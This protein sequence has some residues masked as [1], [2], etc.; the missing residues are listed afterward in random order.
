MGGMKLLIPI[1]ELIDKDAE[2]VRLGK[3]L[4]KIKVEIEKISKKLE[5]PGFVSK[6]PKAVVENEVKKLA[7]LELKLAGLLEQISKISAL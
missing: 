2:L 3:N 5:N 4:D 1:A 7:D 6:A